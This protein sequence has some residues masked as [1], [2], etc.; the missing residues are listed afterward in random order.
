M[1]RH[2]GNDCGRLER[3]ICFGVIL[4]LVA[5]AGGVILKQ[6]TFNP[7]V[8]VARQIEQKTPPGNAAALEAI[9]SFPPELKPFGPPESFSPDNLYDKIDGKA[10]LYLAA[11][12][13][14]MRCQ[15]F[16]LKNAPDE[17]LEW[18]VYDMGTLPQAF[19]VFS[20]QRRAEGQTLDLTAYAYKTK[21]ALYFVCGSNYVEAIASS[22]NEPLTAALRKLADRF[23]AADPAATARLPELEIL[24]EENQVAGSF[25]LQ[26]SDAFGF[27]QFKKVFS[28]QY[29][30]GD[31]EVTAFVTSCAT[32]EAAAQLRDSYRTFL[33]ANGGK[34]IPAA[35]ADSRAVEIM[36][37][38]EFIFSHG[39]RVA[40]V[41][42][43]PS[44]VVAETLAD[45]LRARLAAR[46][47]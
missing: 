44:R 6:F 31:G 1:M 19:S 16:A 15:R 35:D 40:G 22:S 42:A 46:G 10:E 7:A 24:P 36:G 45:R 4:V 20:L 13:V 29:R 26:T 27:D 17:W 33:L 8:L 5:A 9:V 28:A 30:V 25:V 47:K 37:G 39:T 38:V 12:F 23:V 3:W 14:R 21:N 41:H 43:A 2:A 11:G 32:P 18:F 34:D